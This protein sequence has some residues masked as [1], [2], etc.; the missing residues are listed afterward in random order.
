M[1]IL[2]KILTF[3]SGLIALIVGFAMMVFL[4]KFMELN[5]YVNRNYFVGDVYD[6]GA[7]RI[8]RWL[9]DRSYLL[10]L[11]LVCCGLFLLTI[12]SLYAFY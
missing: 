2:L 7:F 5:D 1:P 8:D 6:A 9:F 4:E 10:S 12:F 3:L 11:I